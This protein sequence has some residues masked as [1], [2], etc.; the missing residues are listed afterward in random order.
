[1]SGEDL[2]KN[3]RQLFTTQAHEQVKQH[4]V[5]DD[6]N[7]VKFVFT[8]YIDAD[9]G[10]PCSVTEYVYSQTANGVVIGRQERQYAWKAAWDSDFV[11]DPTADYDPDGDGNE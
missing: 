9:E 5:L 4:I 1:M 3:K 2:S 7:R 8:A 6:Q 11:F 10:T